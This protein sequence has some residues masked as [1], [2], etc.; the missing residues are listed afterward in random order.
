MTTAQIQPRLCNDVTVTIADG[1]TVSSA[2][3]MNGTGLVGITIP[4]TYDGTAMTFKVSSDGTNYFDF[5][6][7][8]GT[9]AAYVVAASRAIGV[10]PADFAGWRFLKLVAGTAQTGDTVITLQTLPL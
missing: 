6:N 5:Y 8:A 7:G 2:A 3:D 4:S 10:A 9:L 1:A